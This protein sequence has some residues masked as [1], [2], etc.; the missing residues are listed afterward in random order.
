MKAIE[1]IN[2]VRVYLSDEVKE[3]A[4]VGGAARDIYYGKQ[5]AD[6]DVGVVLHKALRNDEETFRVMSYIAGLAG[7]HCLRGEVMQAY[8]IAISGGET[9]PA[10][11]F[12]ERLHGNVQVTCEDYKVDFL[13]TRND[14]IVE[15]VHGFDVNFNMFIAG[16]DMQAADYVGPDDLPHPDNA[17]VFNRDAV[18]REVR[19][20]YIIA[21]YDEYM[22]NK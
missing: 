9:V 21:K 17:L 4:V 20:E 18:N 15:M 16:E 7:D 8:N 12:S 1:F 22:L 6:I 2:K 19:G 11:D 5:Y 3:M 10:T 14:S 13:F